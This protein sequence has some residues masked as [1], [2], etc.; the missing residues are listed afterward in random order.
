VYNGVVRRGKLPY[1]Q[2]LKSFELAPRVAINLLIEKD[3]KILL[4]KRAI[5]PFKD[6]WHYPG[7]FLLKD[8]PLDDAVQRVAR[9]ELGIKVKDV[10]LA[11]VFENLTGDPRGHV[12]DVIYRSGPVGEPD[13]VDTNL[14]VKYFERLPEKIGFGHRKI[15]RRL[16]CS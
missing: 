3:G 11:G 8:E 10:E 16:G 5:E 9:D 4:A 2:F 1:D 12:V 7:S 6:H 14:E 15:L 13:A